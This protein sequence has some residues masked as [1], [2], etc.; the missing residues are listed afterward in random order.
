MSRILVPIDGSPQSKT[1]FE[2]ACET[3]SPDEIVLLHVITPSTLYA[4]DGGAGMYTEQLLESQREWAQTQ[5]EELISHAEALDVDATIETETDVGRPA[6]IIV[7]YAA[8]N[9]V[10]HIVMGSSG[11]D[12]A[13]RILLGSVAET[14]VRRAP[15]PVT[16]VR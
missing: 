10:D 7:E 9:D 2:H 13:A 6:R 5:F 1:A 4:H 3:I 14:V 15:V 12:G 16:V 11:R 8:D